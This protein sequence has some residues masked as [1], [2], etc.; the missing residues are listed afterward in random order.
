MQTLTGR[1]SRSQSCCPGT[2]SRACRTS[3]DSVLLASCLPKTNPAAASSLLVIRPVGYNVLAFT[4]TAHT[5]IDS[6]KHHNP[7]ASSS[8]ST[9]SIS[10]FPQLDP[11]KLGGPR[12]DGGDALVQMSRLHIVLDDGSMSGSGPGFVSSSSAP[13]SH[14]L[15]CEWALTTLPTLVHIPGSPKSKPARRLR[16]PL[17]SADDPQHLHTRLPQLDC[18]RT[19]AGSSAHPALRNR[20]SQRP[21]PGHWY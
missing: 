18:P 5:K 11:L 3:R 9:S 7:F 17:C 10:P 1:G 14:P 15:F 4:Q 2:V 16:H 13:F 8:S 20:S 12:V 19:H 6:N 21:E